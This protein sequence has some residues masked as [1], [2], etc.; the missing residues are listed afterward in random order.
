MNQMFKQYSG[1]LVRE[2]DIEIKFNDIESICTETFE[3]IYVFTPKNSENYLAQETKDLFE[4]A[5]LKFERLLILSYPP[6]RI[7]PIHIDGF[8]APQRPSLNVILTEES[9]GFIEYFNV[10]TDSEIFQ[11]TRVVSKRDGMNDNYEPTKRSV[12]ILKHDQCEKIDSF[13]FSTKPTLIRI[14]MPHRVINDNK[15]MCRHI[16]IMR[17]LNDTY[18]EVKQKL[19]NII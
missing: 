14:D 2:F 5:K 18:D 11:I 4:R 17:F 15:N 10:N 1:E 19:L 16:V 3:D 9:T 13:K 8:A 12:T 7:G 6:G